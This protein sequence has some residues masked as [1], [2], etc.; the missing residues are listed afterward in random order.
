M[1]S[2]LKF[3]VIVSVVVALV[4][5]MGVTPQIHAR[6]VET[7]TR[8][9]DDVSGSGSWSFSSFFTKA[10]QKVQAVVA[11]I[12]TM[13]QKQTQ[14]FTSPR[15]GKVE[16]AAPI[17]A[18]K[19]DVAV[20]GRRLNVERINGAPVTEADRARL[21]SQTILQNFRDKPVVQVAHPGRPA[22]PKL[23]KTKSGVPTLSLFKELPPKRKLA[24]VSESREWG[25]KIDWIPEMNIG[26]EPSLRSVDWIL[27][28]VELPEVVRIKAETLETPILMSKADLDEVAKDRVDAPKNAERISFRILSEEEFITVERVKNVAYTIGAET[29]YSLAEVKLFTDEDLF[30]LRTMI[31]TEKGSQCHVAMGLL[32]KLAESEKESYRSY[33][34]LNLSVCLHKSGLFTES[35]E[36]L[37][38]VIQEGSRENAGNAIR[39]LLADLPYEFESHAY[40]VLSQLKDQKIVP[41]DLQD[42]WNL[43]LAR[44][45]A[46]VDEYGTAEKYGKRVAETSPHFAH[47]QYIVSVAEYAQGKTQAS[48]DRQN[49]LIQR[50]QTRKEDATL[51]AFLTLNFART[52]FQKRD[53]NQSIIHFKE[54]RKDNPLWLQALT[55]QG[56]AQLLVKDFAGAIGNMYSVH[57][58]FF[59]NVYKPES[60]V[61]RT[62]GYLNI[63]QYADAYR[64]LTQLE[65]IYRP[66]L[67]AFGGL[68]E[69]NYSGELLYNLVV[70]TLKDQKQSVVEG[71]PTGMLKEAARHRD[72]L[73]QQTAINNR[74]DEVGRY[75]I[76]TDRLKKD[77]QTSLWYRDQASKRAKDLE[78]K[79]AQAAKTSGHAQYVNEWKNSLIVETDAVEYYEFE[80]SISQESSRFFDHLKVVARPRLDALSEK[81]RVLAGQ[82]LSRRMAQMHKELVQILENNELLRYEVFSGS[83]ENIRFQMAGGTPSENRIPAAVKPQSKD[84]QWNFD[85]EYW[86]DEIGHYRSGLKNNCPQGDEGAQKRA[87]STDSGGGAGGGFPDAN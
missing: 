30:A 54:I 78:K 28:N 77:R 84:L 72:F 58:P 52:A 65:K 50:L 57:A 29:P 40:P 18:V 85:G 71:V 17:A 16:A 38:R 56:W 47:A 26:E 62:I 86:E 9:M 82:A 27:P 68:K 49:Q 76:N 14:A 6:I 36:R 48:L 2:V 42:R 79:L 53:Y 31:L 55:E 32:H 15:T 25:G 37:L 45:A 64:T 13:V 4:I 63:C 66:M 10:T 8:Q 39:I 43:S 70:K 21:D 23:A 60:Y 81:L 41:A 22:D 1:K 61:V 51:L 44:A 19:P 3:Q 69:K 35:V 33:G 74:V 75:S 46:R 34:N 5:S 83:G 11:G 20:P 59:A 24:G 80:G 73:N 7:E 87:D 12:A 67:T